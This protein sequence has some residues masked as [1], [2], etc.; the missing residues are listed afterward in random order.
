VVVQSVILGPRSLEVYNFKNKIQ[1]FDYVKALIPCTNARPHN[2][3]DIMI[4]II[5]KKSKIDVINFEKINVHKNNAFFTIVQFFL[6]KFHHLG[7]Q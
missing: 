6:K 1:M 5:F 4:L 3:K 7:T 2:F